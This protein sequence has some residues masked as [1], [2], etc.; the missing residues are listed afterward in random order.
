MTVA[1]HMFQ[2]L[3]GCGT[4]TRE[5]RSLWMAFPPKI[6]LALAIGTACAVPL[7]PALRNILRRLLARAPATEETAEWIWCTL[8]GL[9]AMLFLAGGSY[10]PFI[11]FRF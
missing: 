4:V 8:L 7:A 10:N 5:A 11:Y 6:L 1:D 2:S 3:V 9:T